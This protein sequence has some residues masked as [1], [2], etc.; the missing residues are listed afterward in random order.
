MSCG[1]HCH[2]ARTYLLTQRGPEGAT[3][4][5][6]SSV[7]FLFVKSATELYGGVIDRIPKF[8]QTTY[9]LITIRSH[10]AGAQR[11]EVVEF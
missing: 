4:G 6:L 5:R 1:S 11:C 3:G 7:L 2:L 8:W 10:H 9:L